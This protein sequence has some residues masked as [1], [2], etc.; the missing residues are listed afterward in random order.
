MFVL[1]LN[2]TT[3]GQHFSR[4]LKCTASS[5]LR[6]SAQVVSE[7]PS[8]SSGKAL[9]LADYHASSFSAVAVTDS[10]GHRGALTSKWWNTYR[11]VEMGGSGSSVAGQPT[12]L[13]QGKAFDNYWFR[14]Y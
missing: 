7:S 6:S 8:D 13:Y 10:L 12:A 1:A 5:C 3:T 14:E 9:P 2:D 4:A 11:I